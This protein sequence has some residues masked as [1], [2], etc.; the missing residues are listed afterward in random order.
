MASCGKCGEQSKDGVKFCSA[1][2]APMA[3]EARA[4]S[5]AMTDSA[6]A[7]LADAA[8]AMSREEKTG[9]KFVAPVPVEPGPAPS[10]SDLWAVPA[11]LPIKRGGAA[12]PAPPARPAPS[13]LTPVLAIG[14]AAVLVIGAAW[15]GLA[16]KKP[17]AAALEPVPAPAKIVETAPAPL[18]PAAP[19][20][21][22]SGDGASLA[23]ILEATAPEPA[24]PAPPPAASKRPLQRADAV[25]RPRAAAELPNVM[26]GKVSTLLGKADAY[27]SS[28]Q[29]D[30]AMAMAESALEL[31]PSSGAA[32]AMINKAKTRQMEAL[33]SGS[34]ID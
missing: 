9:F 6:G 23:E 33:R 1:C 11:D 30:K 18:E 34:S 2:G 22:P 24:P 20:Q 27:I 16:V 26:A 4:A 7:P 13:R 17:G 3:A 14:A 5:P 21:V 28:R 25:A 29:Y 19:A 31:D 15:Y 8:P 32:K 12:M 10:G